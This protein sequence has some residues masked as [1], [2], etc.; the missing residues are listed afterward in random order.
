MAERKCQGH[1]LSTKTSDPSGSRLVKSTHKTVLTVA[2]YRL[3]H[4]PDVTAENLTQIE[5]ACPN[6]VIALCATCHF[7][8]RAGGHKLGGHTFADPI[9]AGD[10]PAGPLAEE[11]QQV[12]KGP[13]SNERNFGD[14]NSFGEVPSLRMK[15][16]AAE[17]SSGSAQ[18]AQPAQNLKHAEGVSP[19][20][21]HHM[22][23]PSRS[24]KK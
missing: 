19:S 15:G 20:S 5:S 13:A 18:D 14:R 16:S 8:A 22:L 12:S 3:K 7:H 9:E 6:G 2:E 11:A 4:P 17:K 21:R 24:S 1:L 23:E 10:K